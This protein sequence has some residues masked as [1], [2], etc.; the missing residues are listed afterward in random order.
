MDQAPPTTQ[1]LSKAYNL[2]PPHPH[3]CIRRYAA[4]LLLHVIAGGGGAVANR[5]PR[6]ATAAS[7]ASTKNSRNGN[8]GDF[9]V[10]GAR[11]RLRHHGLD[12]PAAD[13]AS[14]GAEGHRP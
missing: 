2:P 8:L 12:G 3:L 13:H 1:P 14:A 4:V 7:D 9:R 5:H 6:P 10:D 11:V